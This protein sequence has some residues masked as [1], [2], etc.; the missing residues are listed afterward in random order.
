MVQKLLSTELEFMR[1]KN[2]AIS[3]VPGGL[4]TLKTKSQ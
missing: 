1:K 3:Q 4:E 2:R